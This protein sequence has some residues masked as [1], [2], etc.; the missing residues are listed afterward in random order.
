MPEINNYN[1]LVSQFDQMLKFEDSSNKK[2]Y[3]LDKLL[4]NTRKQL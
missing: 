4:K 2:I 3:L 1:T